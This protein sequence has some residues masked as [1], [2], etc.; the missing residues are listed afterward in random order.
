MS[1][2]KRNRTYY[3]DFRLRDAPRLQI[4]SGTSNKALAKSMERTL[5]NLHREGRFDLIGLLKDKK[6]TIRQLHNAA[7]KGPQALDILRAQAN[8]PT[9]GPLIEE[10]FEWLAS[11]SG[12]NR[13]GRRYAPQTVRRYRVSWE[14]F[15]EVLPN[16]KDAR[17][18]DLTDGFV[19]DYKRTRVRAEGGF[20]R[21]SNKDGKAPSPATINR[22]LTALGSF[23]TWCEEIRELA[24]HRPKQRREREAQGRE[25]W[26]APE[27][28][29]AVK[30]ECPADWWPLFATLIRT[31]MRI[32]EAQGLVWADVLLREDTG[33]I[34]IHEGERR[35]KTS[36]SVRD[37]PVSKPL[38]D[39][40]FRHRSR[41]PSGPRDPVFP[42][43]LNDYGKARATWRKVCIAA[44]L[45]DGRKK[46]KPTATIH[47]LR[48]TYG[49]MAAQKGI[50]LVHLQ[51]F[52]GH[53]SPHM[54]MRYMQHAPEAFF[55]EAAALIEEALG[56]NT[57][58]P[59]QA[60]RKV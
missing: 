30:A 42:N 15:F 50:P 27:E 32:G 20:A 4:S 8:S 28:I 43:P 36:S 19:A 22:D 52:L 49:V 59:G 1:I 2:W 12:I 44:G 23:L 16:S 45:H 35:V 11:P 53:K 57:A 3:L 21:N 58:T 54:T 40:L 51:R 7:V 18:S 38:A 10:W 14:G 37:V 9:L 47:D 56:D 26:L 41:V 25:R 48:H 17:L 34:T 55:D 33:R 60:L 31:G 6:V 5:Q 39:L 46:P 24:I 29:Q 13:Q